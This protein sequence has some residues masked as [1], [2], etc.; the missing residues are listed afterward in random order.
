MLC[1]SRH[2]TEVS[3]SKTPK[4]GGTYRQKALQPSIS[5]GFLCINSHCQ[6]TFCKKLVREFVPSKLQRGRGTVH[7][8][9][10]RIKPVESTIANVNSYQRLWITGQKC[11]HRNTPGPHLISAA[12]LMQECTSPVSGSCGHAM[13]T[14][15]QTPQKQSRISIHTRNSMTAYG[16]QA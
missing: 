1:A 12:P 16:E 13:P 7:H 10:A 4:L 6:G 9:T 15:T 5:K 11:N 3:S 2:Q 14:Y 8:L